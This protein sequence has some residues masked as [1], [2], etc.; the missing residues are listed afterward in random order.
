VIAALTAASCTPLILPLDNGVSGFLLRLELV[1]K[2]RVSLVQFH[3]QV[4]RR[5]EERHS[6]TYSARENAHAWHKLFNWASRLLPHEKRFEPLR[7][8]Y[9]NAMSMAV[10]QADDFASHTWP[11][12]EHSNTSGKQTAGLVRASEDL[13]Q[14]CIRQ[15]IRPPFTIA[16]SSVCQPGPEDEPTPSQRHGNEA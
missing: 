3:E 10:T 8:G 13:K 15:Q 16:V 4:S 11:A 2:K 1:E 7:Q 6:T 9:M 14:L 5:Y 12:W